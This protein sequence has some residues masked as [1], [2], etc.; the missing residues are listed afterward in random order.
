MELSTVGVVRDNGI[1]V[2]DDHAIDFQR[3]GLQV[4]SGQQP[5]IRPAKRGSM[6]SVVESDDWNV[7]GNRH[8][9]ELERIHA[10]GESG[11]EPVI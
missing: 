1:D 2:T 8:H 4:L 6:R 11:L 7:I 3:G 10:C 9:I 5:S